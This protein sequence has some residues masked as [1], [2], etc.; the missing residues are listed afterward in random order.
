MPTHKLLLCYYVLLWKHMVCTK[1]YMNVMTECCWRLL[2]A[3]LAGACYMTY[4]SIRG[5]RPTQHSLAGSGFV[6]GIWQSGWWREMVNDVKP[7]AATRSCQRWI[8]FTFYLAVGHGFRLSVVLP[9][10]IEIISK[11]CIK[12]KLCCTLFIASVREVMCL[13][14]YVRILFSCLI[15]VWMDPMKR[16][17]N[18]H[19]VIWQWSCESGISIILTTSGEK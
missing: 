9:L 8:Y 2:T 15:K 18:E 11:P 12:T 6:Q 5:G 17:S 7:K 10:S 19:M 1:R 14:L 16:W 4:C 3:G 13:L